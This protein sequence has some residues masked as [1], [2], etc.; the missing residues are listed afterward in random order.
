MKT[1]GLDIGT[2]SIGWGIVNE[3]ESKIEKCGVYI[4]PEGVK[5]EKSNE[6][7]KAAERTRYRLARRLKFRRKLRKYETLKVL[8]EYD[9]CPL[10]MEEL[11]TWRTSKIYPTSTDFVKWYRTDDNINWEPYYL[12]KKCVETKAEKHEVG[13]ALYHIAQRRGFLSNRKETTKAT[14]GKV[15]TS[16]DELSNA[17]GDKTLGQYFYELKQAGE[18]VRGRY[19]S[20]KIHYETEF[21]KICEIQN[22]PENLKER[23]YKAIFYQR[24]LKS[25]KF[26]VGK[27]TLETDK[28]RCPISHYDFEEFRMLQFINSIKIAKNATEDDKKDFVFLSAE[29]KTLIKS[30]FYRISKPSFPFADI[31]KKIAGKNEYWKFNY[32][33]DA[34]VPGCPV[35]TSFI[36]IFG[37]NWKHTQIDKYDIQD[38]WHVLFDFDDDEKLHL[39]ALN[40][41]N[42]DETLAKKFCAIHLQQGYANLSLKAIHKILPFLRK[43]YIYSTAVFLANIPSMIGPELY[44]QHA[45]EIEQEVVHITETLKDRNKIITVTN[46]SLE[47]IFKDSEHN[48]HLEEWDT[49]LVDKQIDDIYGKKN[50]AQLEQTAQDSIKNE[51]LEKI[52]DVLKIAVTNRANDYKYHMLR[53]DDLIIDYLNS[54]GWEIKK[55]TKLYHPSDT[56][57]TFE[58]PKVSEDGKTYLGSPRTA[59]VRNPVAMRALYQLRKLINYLILTGDIDST[60]RINI[61]LANEVNDKNWRKAIEEFQRANAT[62]NESYR[63]QITELCKEA[64]FDI[65]PTDSD[66]KK[67]RLWKE[68][69]EECP[70]TGK[71]ISITDLFGPYPKFDFEHTIP[72]SMSYDD[73]LEN[74]TLC[75]STYNRNIKKQHIP[76]ELPEYD[77]ISARF[78]KYYTD[79]IDKC[80]KTIEANSTRGGGY[81]DPAIK[82]LRLVKKHKAQLELD[83]YIGKLKRFKTT[84]VT[85]GFKHSQLNDTRIIT[86]FALS[87]LKSVFNY[88]QPVN[89]A[90]TDLFK[91]QWG[92]LDRSESKDR[93]NYRHHAVDALTIACVNRSKFNL[94][95]EVIR[96]SPN[97]THL[98]FPKP[99][100]SF[101][102]DVLNAVQY[103]IPKHFYD[104]NALRQTKKILRDRTGK[105]I[106]KNGKPVYITGATARGSLHKDT[107]Y[108]CITTP[109]EKG[110]P[111]QKIYVQRISCSMLTEKSVDVI[112]DKAIKKAFIDN[113]NSGTQTIADMQAKGI[114]LPP[115]KNGKKIYAKHIRV[116]AKPTNPIALKKH[117]H[118]ADKNS[119]EYKQSTYV[120]NDENYFI[121]LY[122]GKNSKGIDMS[123]YIVSNL[124]ESVKNKQKGQSLYP[125]TILKGNDPLDFYKILKIGKT[126]ILKTSETEDVLSL[127]ENELF[128]RLYSVIGIKSDGRIKLNHIMIN[129]TWSFMQSTPTNQYSKHRL[130]SVNN[131][132]LLVEGTDF[133]ITPTGEI[134]AR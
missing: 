111:G 81:I 15:S 11:N 41:L 85:S 56:D 39:F 52:D 12:R 34:T 125:D 99:W 1:L 22:I 32:R 24:K 10:T 107:I 91:R 123:G 8:I 38:I 66:L 42:L 127:P 69:N 112:I 84:Q 95:C 79:A 60:T 23:L 4:F 55:N 51:I 67:F 45:D 124:L 37:E 104:D 33:N 64:G 122:R 58:N 90:M 92:L 131:L 108:G 50:W 100:D 57:Y 114:L 96:K 54:K 74:L 13:R 101:D 115:D 129:Q 47:A 128:N 97:G 30:L 21:N 29:E 61:E 87:Y 78:E 110:I 88:V 5:K 76:S 14:D 48:F 102:T 26:L 63:K 109:P 59:S 19:T 116:K 9:M 36:S 106:L 86:K 133:T 89:G 31:A 113:L 119:K 2:N 35:T 18:K 6:S 83:Y 77:I 132:F 98:N 75:E 53:T 62:A 7:S 121:A 120:V 70:Y 118:S 44:R 68:Q 3:S 73:S 82:D 93:S 43:G 49:S 40:N 126:V 103:I 94:L 80:L 17:M 25:Q 16:I 117:Q 105:P 130:E 65:T 134:I 27:C 20:R 28:P 71:K 46:N 72:R